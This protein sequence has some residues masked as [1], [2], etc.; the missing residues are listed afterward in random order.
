MC[1]KGTGM[2]R[3]A[4]SEEIKDWVVRHYVH[5]EKTG[6]DTLVEE[7]R[8]TYEM[9]KYEVY[10]SHYRVFQKAPDG[11]VD[12]VEEMIDDFGE[13]HSY[14]DGHYWVVERLAEV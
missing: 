3:K 2:E 7:V 10:A 8:C 12:G 5:D 14:T 11:G 4:P 6:E 9:A 1:M 13:V